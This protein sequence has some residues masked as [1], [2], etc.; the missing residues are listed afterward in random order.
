VRCAMEQIK[1][2]G[3]RASELTHQILAFSRRQTLRPQVVLLDEVIRGM[4]QLLRRTIGEDLDLQIV[5]SSPLAAAELDPHQFEQVVMNLVLNARDAMPTGGL[6]T[7]ETANVELDEEFARTH[8]G[9]PPGSYVMLRISDTGVGMDAA[10]Q[11]RIFEPFYTT[12]AI[13]AG[14]G[15]GLSTVYGIVKQSNGSIFVTSEPGRGSSFAIYL[16]KAAQPDASQERPV[17]SQAAS[18]GRETIMVVEDEEA[19]RG[20][21]QLFLAGAGYKTLMFAS[22]QEALAALQEAETG[23][24]LLL[25]DVMLSGAMQGHDLARAVLAVRPELPVLYISGYARDALV[26]AGRLDEGVNLLEKPFTS[27]SLKDMVRQVLDMH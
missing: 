16:P 13:G 27:S 5:E 4:E 25:T 24:D 18:G 22:A 15:L 9:T 8:A 14:T 17:S 7:V 2:A 26:H 1:R 10:I 3:D 12:K 21:I 23:L 11:A 20:L 19:L 6:L